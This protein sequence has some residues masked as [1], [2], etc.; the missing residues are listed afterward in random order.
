MAI[1][2]S[3]GALVYCGLLWLFFIAGFPTFDAILVVYSVFG[4]NIITITGSL[5]LNC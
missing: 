2:P 1:S 3:S 4:N 5:I